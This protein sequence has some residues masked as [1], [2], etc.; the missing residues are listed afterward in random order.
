MLESLIN[1]YGL[2]SQ[3]KLM[4]LCT[5]ERIAEQFKKSDCFVL[6]S[7]SETFGV[8]YVEALACGIPVI[9]TR[10]GGPEMFVNANNGLMIDINDI[11]QLTE[12]MDYMY[13]HIDN[14]N[15]KDISMEIRKKFS[16]K[17]VATELTNLYRKILITQ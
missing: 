4:G 13:N 10:C 7:K 2:N 12:A 11:E 14:Y 16:A 3:I 9:A 6:V 15:R 5:R 8:A 1:K 17:V